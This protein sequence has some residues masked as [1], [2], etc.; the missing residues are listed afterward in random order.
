MN[1][2]EIVAASGLDAG[3]EGT[4]GDD[5][6]YL[7]QVERTLG[8]FAGVFARL[9]STSELVN[10]APVD[11]VW[12]TPAT[13]VTAAR[14]ALERG[15]IRT[16]DISA[17]YRHMRPEQLV[18]ALA[19]G[20]ERARSRQGAPVLTHGIPTLATLRL[21]GVEVIG[22]ADW[23]RAAVADR[24]RDLAV[25]LRHLVATTGPGTVPVFASQLADDPDPVLL[26]WYLLAVEL[27]P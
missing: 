27:I 17:A 6:F 22:F 11:P 9:S 19:Q 25:A 15:A 3:D 8:L 23:T 4:P 26:D 5:T 20:E 18:D 16:E 24:H 10:D 21:D 14:D 1:L 12:G 13:I 7:S 2:D